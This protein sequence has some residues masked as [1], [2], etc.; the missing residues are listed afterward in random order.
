M[1]REELG[2]VDIS[3]GESV[4]HDLNRLNIRGALMPTKR[5]SKE[6]KEVAA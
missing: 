4:E 6:T 3:R 5:K 2:E 1:E